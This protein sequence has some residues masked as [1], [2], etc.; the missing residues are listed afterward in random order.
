MKKH[1]ESFF[2]GRHD[3]SVLVADDDPTCRND[4]RRNLHMFGFDAVHCATNGEEA[5]ELYREREDEIILVVSDLQMPGMNGDELFRR[6]RQKGSK[7]R[8]LLT[9]GNGY[10]VDLDALRS[11]G[12]G[13]FVHK[14]FTVKQFLLAV[15]L[16][17]M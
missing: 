4:M 2:G 10:G 17:L 13:G 16:A 3:A 7:A 5:F 6:L 14:P 12:L 8:M 11:E 15:T 9:S 1:I